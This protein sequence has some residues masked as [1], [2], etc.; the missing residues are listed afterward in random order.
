MQAITPSGPWLPGVQAGAP[1]PLVAQ[2][3]E[4]GANQWPS[5]EKIPHA[6]DRAQQRE[7]SNQL[8][9]EGFA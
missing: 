7:T 8:L 9:E 5:M 4:A 2:A 6:I 1:E 3:G